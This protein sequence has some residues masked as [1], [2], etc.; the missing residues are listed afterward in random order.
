MQNL[1]Q[2]LLLFI[3]CVELTLPDFSNNNNFRDQT[4][5]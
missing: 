1:I 4:F 5:Y 2:N 3:A